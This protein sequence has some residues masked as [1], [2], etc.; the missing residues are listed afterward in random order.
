MLRHEFSELE[1]AALLGASAPQ[2]LG[3]PYTRETRN[4]WVEHGN[5]YV[6]YIFTLAGARQPAYGSNCPLVFRQRYD[7]A[8]GTLFSTVSGEDLCDLSDHYAVWGFFDF[9]DPPRA[10]DPP[11]AGAAPTC[12]LPEFPR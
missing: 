1:D 6:D 10:G 8:D 3:H 11:Q 7:F 12:P 4:D 2:F 9:R 5:G